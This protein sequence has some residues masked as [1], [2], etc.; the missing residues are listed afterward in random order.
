MISIG[1]TT[2]EHVRDIYQKDENVFDQGCYR[3]FSTALFGDVPSSLL[4]DFREVIPAVDYMNTI[5]KEREE[6]QI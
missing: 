2:N 6:A 3:N 4:P 1:Q 5:R